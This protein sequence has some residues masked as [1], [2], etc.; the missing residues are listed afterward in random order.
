MAATAA[1][2]AEANGVDDLLARRLQS[3]GVWTAAGRLVGVGLVA[4]ATFYLPRVMT[5]ADFGRFVLLQTVISFAVIAACGGLN[6][7]VI[8]KTASRLAANDGTGAAAAFRQ[9]AVAMTRPLTAATLGVFALFAFF[10][11]PLFQIQSGQYALYAAI[12]A[13]VASFAMQQFTA[14]SLRGFHDYPGA[15]FFTGQSGGP[16]GMALFLLFVVCAAA[17][18]GSVGLYTALALNAAGCAIV[19]PCFWARLRNRLHRTTETTA[20]STNRTSSGETAW[21]LLREASPFLA[22][23]LLSQMTLHLDVWIAGAH[24]AENEL[25]LYGAGRRL[26]ALIG[27]PLQLVNLS[28]LSSIAELHYARRRDRLQAMLSKAA[29]LAFLPTLAAVVVIAAAPRP[30]L[31]LLFGDFYADAAAV[32]VVLA[33]GACVN[34][35]TGPC[36]FA[37]TMTGRAKVSAAINA[38]CVVFLVAAGTYSVRNYGMTGAAWSATAALVLNNLIHLVLA[39]RLVG[40]WTCWTPLG[41]SKL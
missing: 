38:A 16:V 25:A 28:V 22:V 10:S 3:A 4:A 6:R 26:A 13:C 32:T 34:S 23:N 5:P 30:L 11:E 20:A 19:L 7:L 27:L 2:S 18:L 33:L 24:V 36:I 37:L 21:S 17:S 12:A 9:A 1:G 14:E 15:G 41:R 29:T 39:R 8:Q 31:T 35:F 40:V